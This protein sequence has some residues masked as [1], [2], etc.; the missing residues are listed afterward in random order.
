MKLCQKKTMADSVILDYCGSGFFLFLIWG[1]SIFSCSPGLEEMGF[2]N[3]LFFYW[4]EEKAFG[5]KK[6]AKIIISFKV[7]NEGGENEVQAHHLRY[8][9]AH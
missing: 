9:L 2:G 7:V 8:W 3:I 5:K 4:A 6:G 1:F